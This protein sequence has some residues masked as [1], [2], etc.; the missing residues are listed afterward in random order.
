MSNGPI[1]EATPAAK[2][3]SIHVALTKSDGRSIENLSPLDS[4]SR[5]ANTSGT[6]PPSGLSHATGAA[7][8]PAEK[9]STNQSQSGGDQGLRREISAIRNDIDVLN[10]AISILQSSRE[11]KLRKLIRKWRSAGR[12]AAEILFDDAQQ[13]IKDMGG[14]TAWK[15]QENQKMKQ[16][17]EFDRSE[18]REDFVRKAARENEARSGSRLG[19]EMNGEIEEPAEE[20]AAES[21]TIAQEANDGE[22]GDDVSAD[23]FM[24]PA[25]MLI[26]TEWQEFT[27][28]T[29]LRTLNIDLDLIRYDE[30]EQQWIS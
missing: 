19:S 26:L 23:D 7:T 1:T 9:L 6:Y 28:G 2:G 24:P 4:E 11:E 14:L 8:K 29:M 27:M 21:E 5:V 25:V 16:L 30:Q 18:E 3:N 12:D 13:R 10:Q 22:D 17:R 20:A 15:A